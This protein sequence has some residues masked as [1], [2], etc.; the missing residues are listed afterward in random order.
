MNELAWIR[1]ELFEIAAMPS[2]FQGE[3]FIGCDLVTQ[4]R[5]CEIQD[6]LADILVKLYAA[7]TQC[8]FPFLYRTK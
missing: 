7:E 4:E 3:P 1:K 6:R 5:L 8:R 2:N